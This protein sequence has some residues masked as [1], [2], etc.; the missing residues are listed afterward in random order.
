LRITSLFYGLWPSFLAGRRRLLRPHLR[1][2]REEAPEPIRA[3]VAPAPDEDRIKVEMDEVLE[4]MSR[5]GRENLTENDLN[6]LRRASEILR[7]RRT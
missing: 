6:V 4:K 2:Y 5:V 7:R 1:V 3:A